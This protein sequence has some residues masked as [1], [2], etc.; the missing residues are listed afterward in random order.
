MGLGV[1]LGAAEGFYLLAHVILCLVLPLEVGAFEFAAAR[2]VQVFIGSALVP[3]LSKRA[4]AWKQQQQTLQL[5]TTTGGP[6]PASAAGVVPEGETGGLEGGD[7]P[8]T[9]A[10]ASR[11]SA[12]SEEPGKGFEDAGTGQGLTGEDIA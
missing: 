1:V 7:S 3:A 11:K 10:S 6:A 9:T 12:R 5:V 2:L 4:T 8:K